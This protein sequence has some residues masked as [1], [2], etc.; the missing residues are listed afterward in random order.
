MVVVAVVPVAAAA[1]DASMILRSHYCLICHPYSIHSVADVTPDL[2]YSLHDAHV[3]ALNLL[4][5]QDLIL[6]RQSGAVEPVNRVGS[7]V[8]GLVPGPVPPVLA[9]EPV[10]DPVTVLTV[11]AV[12][13]GIA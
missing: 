9:L 13:V 8:P 11:G 2:V 10:L 6:L 3:L 7:A 4:W 5:H 1:V 12:V